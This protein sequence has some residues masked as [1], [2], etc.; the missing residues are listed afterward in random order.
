MTDPFPI[1]SM[2]G[3]NVPFAVPK[4]PVHVVFIHCSASDQAA[5]DDAAVIDQWHRRR[6]WRG[7][8]Y[9]VFIRGDGTIQ[10]GRPLEDVPAA[11]AGHNSG[12]IALCL[13]GFHQFSPVQFDSLRRLADAMDAAYAAQGKRLR[14]RGH[15]E[16]AAKLCPNFDYRVVLGLDAGGF[17]RPAVP[18]LS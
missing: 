18:A 2:P 6:G 5:H 8:G 1:L 7:I 11:Q 15:R 13:H 17:R 4:R 9:H 10:R 14:W 16:V 12:S 3:Q